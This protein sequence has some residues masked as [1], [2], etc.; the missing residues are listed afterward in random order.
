MKIDDIKK[1]RFAITAP[2]AKKEDGMNNTD[3]TVESLIELLKAEDAKQI[4]SLK[5]AFPL[6]A[7]AA[8][9]WLIGTTAAFI[10]MMETSGGIDTDFYLRGLLLFLFTGLAIALYL[11]IKRLNRID[12][13]EPV[14]HFLRKAVERYRFMS[15]PFFLFS[16]A[17]SFI[18]ALAASVYINDV[19]LR[20][21]D[22]AN[23]AA[24]IVI[25][26]AFVALV[27]LVGFF[28]TKR[29]WKESKGPVFEE[30]VKMQN[31]LQQDDES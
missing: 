24:G 4:R 5:K 1:Q 29:S 28:A 8:G 16:I 23:T 30:I 20:Y 9:C 2:Q 3:S 31:E 6:W 11:Q 25:S 12:Y 14:I 10:S 27:Y 21:F 19:L 22:I 26:I 15:V 17:A 13:A 18:L 7:I